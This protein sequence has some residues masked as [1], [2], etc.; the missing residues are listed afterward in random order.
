[1]KYI[2]TYEKYDSE[3]YDPDNI[4]F[5]KLLVEFLQNNIPDDFKVSSSYYERGEDVNAIAL[6]SVD[7]RK[8]YAYRHDK[9]VLTIRLLRVNDKQL[10]EV[11]IKP[12]LKVYIKTCYDIVGVDKYFVDIFT[13]FLCEVFKKYSYFNKER[14]C[15][16][17]PTRRNYEYYINKS[18]IDNIM[19]DL[20]EFEVYKNSLKYNL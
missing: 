8:G 12:K 11:K 1:M 5:K 19:E 2:K 20:K 18:D 9:P 7:A 15:A 16:H 3:L 4:Y 10:R 14:N 13:S 17:Y 6:M